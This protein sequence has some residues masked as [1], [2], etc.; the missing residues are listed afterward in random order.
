MADNPA[1]VRP[2]YRLVANGIEGGRLKATLL[3]SPEL[4]KAGAPGFELKDWPHQMAR[5]LR[6]VQLGAAGVAPGDARLLPAIALQI[7]AGGTA[8]T[9]QIRPSDVSI[10]GHAGDAAHDEASWK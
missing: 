5:L 3:M 7:F 1:L 8:E 6:S 10:A 9:I 2:F 4:P